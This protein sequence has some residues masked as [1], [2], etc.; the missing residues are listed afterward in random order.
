MAITKGVN[1]L[2]SRTVIVSIA[3]ADLTDAVVSA[4]CDKLQLEGWTIAGVE[5]TLDADETAH[6]AL[7][8]GNEDGHAENVSL[9]TTAGD[10]GTGVTLALV[11][12]FL[13]FNVEATVT[14]DGDL[15]AFI[16]TVG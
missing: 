5:P 7:Q 2:G 13:N 8:G 10:Y 16:P 3:H 15:E 14:V 9:G 11:A 4:A 12:T 1:G 6:I